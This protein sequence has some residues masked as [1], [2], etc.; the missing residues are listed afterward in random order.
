MTL[1]PPCVGEGDAGVEYCRIAAQNPLDD[2]PHMAVFKVLENHAVSHENEAENTIGIC[3]QQLKRFSVP[4]HIFT[5]RSDQCTAV[6]GMFYTCFQIM[7]N[8]LRSILLCGPLNTTCR[9][10]QSA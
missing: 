7:K 2:D 4:W 5:P 10:T 1:R 3:N 8:E 6:R 9:S